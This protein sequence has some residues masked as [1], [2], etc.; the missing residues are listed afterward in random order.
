MKFEKALSNNLEELVSFVEKR[1]LETGY[2]KDNLENFY[3]GRENGN[4]VVCGCHLK[5]SLK[6]AREIRGVA[7]IPKNGIITKQIN[8]FLCNKAKEKGY[9][10]I[11]AVVD[12]N[13]EGMKSYINFLKKVNGFEEISSYQIKNVIP[14]Y[15]KVGEEKYKHKVLLI[16]HL[17]DTFSEDNCLPL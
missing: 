4:I 13:K 9:K 1:K 5:T 3:I 11:Y 6:A 10:V 16:K 14:R 7:T 8:N 17:S 2:I 15:R 12:P